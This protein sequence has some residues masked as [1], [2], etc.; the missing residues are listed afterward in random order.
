MEIGKEERERERASKTREVTKQSRLTKGGRSVEL[1]SL[2]KRA[3]GAA[4]KQLDRDPTNKGVRKE[5]SKS[6]QKER[7]RQGRE[8]TKMSR[9]WAARQRPS[10]PPL[11]RQRATQHAH[12]HRETQHPA[13]SGH[14]NQA[15]RCNTRERKEEEKRKR[16]RKRW[17]AKKRKGVN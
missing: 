17:G 10:E 3:H 11:S 8:N 14:S 6:E 16:K 12:K 7:K 9:K 13:S 4:L 5:T 2:P 1:F 15:H